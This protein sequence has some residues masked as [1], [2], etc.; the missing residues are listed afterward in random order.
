MMRHEGSD[1]CA[2]FV[3]RQ[4]RRRVIHRFI[5]TVCAVA[6]LGREPL[7]VFACLHRR[8]HQRH[9]GGV[10]GD[11]QVLGQSAFQ[12]QAGHAEG[13][14]LVIELNIGAVVARFGNAPRHAA[15]FS[16]LD[17]L[18]DRRLAG[19]IKQGVLIVGHDQQ[20]HQIFEHRTAPRNEN[21]LATRGDEQPTHREPVVLRN[22]PQGDGNVTAQA[23][24][25]GQQIIEAGVEPAFGDIEPG[26]K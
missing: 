15:Q 22:L 7:Q 8:N 25:G 13:A 19:V 23:R 2:R 20:R 18:L 14:I 17:L 9:G 24:L 10:R 26:G 12:A 3:R 5:K 4:A 1:R 16:I 6:S 11:H 21:W